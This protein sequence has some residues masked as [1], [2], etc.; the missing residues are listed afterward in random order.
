MAADLDALVERAQGLG[1]TGRT[2]IMRAL[3]LTGWK[4]AGWKWTTKPGSSTGKCC[5]STM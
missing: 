2:T 1:L 5:T 3:N 4:A